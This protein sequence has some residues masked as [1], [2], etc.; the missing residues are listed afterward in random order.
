[1]SNWQ[2]TNAGYGAFTGSTVQN[3]LYS[4]T[5]NTKNT[6]GLSNGPTR[7][8]NLYQNTTNN[9][10]VLN[11]P[12]SLIKGP[13]SNLNYGVK[14][15][16][17]STNKPIGLENLTNTCY[18]SACL[19]ILFLVIP[20]TMKSGKVM[21]AFLQLKKTHDKRDYHNFKEVV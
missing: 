20:E 7:Q 1:M 18:I 13:N 17:S 21:Q 16:L 11:R 4:N 6:N 14:S 15:H 12:N 5:N 2:T 9:S 8:N 19:Q 3:K 10:S